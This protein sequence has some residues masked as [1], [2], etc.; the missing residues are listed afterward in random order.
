[1]N[2]G[3]PEFRICLP[4][5]MVSGRR[6]VFV[7]NNPTND[8]D[9]S[10]LDDKKVRYLVYQLEV[11]ESGTPH[12]QGYVEFKDTTSHGTASKLLGIGKAHWES[13]KGDAADNIHYCSKPVDG[14]DCEHCDDAR[15]VGQEPNPTMWGEV[16]K[17]GRP[18]KGSNRSENERETIKWIDERLREGWTNVDFYREDPI[19][20]T[21]VRMIEQVRDMLRAER[22]EEDLEELKEDAR[23][24][25]MSANSLQKLCLEKLKMQGDRTILVVVDPKGG[26]GKSTLGS[27]LELIFDYKSY[28]NAKTQDI[29]YSVKDESPKKGYVID[30]ARSLQKL[31]TEG[32][33]DDYINYQVIENLKDG[34]LFSPKYKSCS[35]R[36]KPP[37]IVILMN[38]WPNL[39]K[40]SY[41]RWDIIEWTKLVAGEYVPGRDY[42]E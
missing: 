7:W 41:D 15:K 21:Q 16:G 39:T 24:K 5:E 30:L 4:Y 13:A 28:P 26:C 18:K 3:I 10:K 9:V 23:E 42:I 19:W 33:T 37:K 32:K 31:D 20:A 14:C 25:M 1:M 29:A 2:S 35:L 38:F 40:L 6:M 22:L 11:G 8:I 34:K 17:V 27:I 12:L 36:F